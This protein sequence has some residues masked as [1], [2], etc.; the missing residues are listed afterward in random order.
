MD[1]QKDISDN[2]NTRFLEEVYTLPDGDTITVGKERVIGPERI[3]NPA[4]AGFECCGLDSICHSS[5]MS[6]DPDM[7]KRDLYGNVVLSGGTTLLT[8]EMRNQTG[9]LHGKNPCAIT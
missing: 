2:E 6:C 8:G 1:A 9:L 4:Y 5:I 7:N 3:F